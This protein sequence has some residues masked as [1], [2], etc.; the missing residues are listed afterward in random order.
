MNFAGFPAGQDDWGALMA[1]SQ[2]GD[3][4]AYRELLQALLPWL[5]QLA[6]ARFRARQ[7]IEDSV[8]D[9]LLTLHAIRHTYDPS[10]PF[11]PWLIAVARRRIVDRLRTKMRHSAREIYLNTEHETFPAPETN[12]IEQES[13][14]RRLREAVARLPEAQ[15][16]A[17]TMLKLE[18]KSLAE[19]AAT[20]GL[21]VAALK[22]S[23][24]RAL[25]NLRR[26]LEKT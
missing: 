11:K 20:T 21:S 25:K 10:R 13:E 4:A 18:E 26:L 12:L 7:D 23:S 22:V 5:R 14:A 16:Q 24:H 1:R 9:V 6:A 15:R 17:V 3:R 8:Q 19:T 2:A